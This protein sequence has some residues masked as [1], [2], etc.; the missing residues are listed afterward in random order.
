MFLCAGTAI[1]GNSGAFGIRVGIG[2]DY[3]SQE[4]FLD[5]LRLLGEDSLVGATLLKRDYLDDKKAILYL[6]LDNRSFLASPREYS[7]EVG[8]EQTDEVYRAVSNIDFGLSGENYRFNG[9]LGFDTKRRFSGSITPGEELTV[10]DG[11]LKYRQVISQRIDGSLRIYGEKVWFDSATTYVYDYGRLGATLGLGILTA[12]FNSISVNLTGELRKVPDSTDL[13]YSLIRGSLGYIGTFLG[14]FSS[15]NVSLEYRDYRLS[16]D[17]DDYFLTTLYGT[18]DW[19][20]SEKYTLGT[21]LSLELFDYA[22]NDFVS[23]DY[24]L[25][26]F[27]LLLKRKL[28]NINLIFGPRSEFYFVDTEYS[29]DDDYYEISASAGFDYIGSKGNLLLLENQVGHRHY[30]TAQI[31]TSDFWFNRLNV[32]GSVGI[33]KNL[34]LDLFFSAEWEWH[35]IDS[36]DNRIFLLTTDITCRF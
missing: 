5:S 8:W 33:W 13:D 36:D 4:Y 14:S 32:I 3:V 24:F 35:E 7:L 34:T 28:G 23:A 11:H 22:V 6:T 20:L 21:N 1:C 27:D 17:F 16:D 26:R 10:L 30:N 25:G 15:G 29:S 9:E 12:D 19:P 18:S 2:Y 31:Y